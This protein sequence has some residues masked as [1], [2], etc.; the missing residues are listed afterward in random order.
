MS[1]LSQMW[2]M[3]LGKSLSPV[4]PVGGVDKGVV[5]EDVDGLREEFFVGFQVYEYVAAAQVLAGSALAHRRLDL[6]AE[7]PFLV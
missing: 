5:A 7:L 4:R 3:L 2:S 6:A 1:S